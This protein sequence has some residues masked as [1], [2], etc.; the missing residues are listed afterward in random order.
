MRVVIVGAGRLGCGYLAP[1]FR[2]GGHDVVL[3]CHSPRTSAA[4]RHAGGWLVTNTATPEPAQPVRG[5]DPVTVGGQ[6][7]HAAVADADLVVV[8]VGVGNVAV[9]C[10]QLVPGL[11]ARAGRPVDVWLA[12][13]ADCADHA[14]A[15]LHET[16]S[17]SGLALPPLGVA[18]AVASVAVS[19]GSW[20]GHR[21]PEFVGDGARRLA[22][23]ATRLRGG[24]PSLPGVRATSQYRA[25]LHE[26]L[27]GFNAGHAM[28]AYL[29][30]LRGHDTIAAAIADPFVRPLV[31]GALL[32]ARHATLAEYR[33]LAGGRR[34]D[35]ERDVH[36]PVAEM[37]ARFADSALGD[38]VGR[39]ARDPMR[40]LG[41]HDRLLGP[42]GL[43]RHHDRHVPA[44]FALGI[45]AAL[46]YGYAAPD[47][48][49]TDRQAST[50][51]NQL[52][53]DGIAATLHQLCG[54]HPGDPIAAAIT[55][56]YRGFVF[57]DDGV[58]FPPAAP[59]PGKE[60]AG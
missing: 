22:I 8:S 12:E 55:S 10:R 45:A 23:D 1:L 54:L 36:R 32:E 15:A 33:T 24:V 17:G 18:G 3:G 48:L 4:V 28:T 29:G 56:R 5:V 57:T 7:W 60:L 38:P 6:D 30:W 9:A 59:G 52:E 16:A 26:K 39:V 47:V 2:A 40:K 43:L 21:I 41:P 25:R 50:L 35:Q 58:R 27:Y 11:A 37:L 34:F 13:N 31:A 14:R 46:L 49:T 51:R 42:V 19:R 20:H 44:H 53:R